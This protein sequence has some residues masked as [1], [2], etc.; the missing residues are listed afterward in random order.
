MRI[1]RKKKLLA[2][3]LAHA[4]KPCMLVKIDTG[5]HTRRLYASCT[6]THRETNFLLLFTNERELLSRVLLHPLRTGVWPETRVDLQFKLISLGATF[7]R[8][9]ARKD[10]LI[11]KYIFIHNIFLT[12]LARPP[13]FFLRSLRHASFCAQVQSS[14]HFWP[15]STWARQPNSTT[16][17]TSTKVDPTLMSTKKLFSNKKGSF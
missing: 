13:V 3:S 17:Q 5:K 12:G 9:M 2:V 16:V 10:Y 14:Q 7:P 11:S 1:K 4:N 8:V 6:N 15:L